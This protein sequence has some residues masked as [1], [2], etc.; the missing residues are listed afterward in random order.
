MRSIFFLLCSW[1]LFS[2][3]TEKCPYAIPH[4]RI[5]IGDRLKYSSASISVLC[6]GLY[7]NVSVVIKFMSPEFYY[8]EESITRELNVTRIMSES[9]LPGF[10]TLYLSG[11]L[12]STNP[13]VTYMVISQ[14]GQTLFDTIYDYDMTLNY[15]IDIIIQLIDRLQA[16]WYYG[17]LHRDIK[18][19]N[20]AFG[21]DKDDEHTIYLFD[22]G[23]STTYPAYDRKGTPAFSPAR[24]LHRTLP[25]DELEC[26]G[27]IFIYLLHKDIPWGI[28]EG[29]HEDLAP[30]KKYITIENLCMVELYKNSSGHEACIAYFTFIRNNQ[31]WDDTVITS[32][33]SDGSSTSGSNSDMSPLFTSNLRGSP[34]SS[35]TS[36]DVLLTIDE[37]EIYPDY[38]SLREILMSFYEPEP[39]VKENDTNSSVDAQQS[40]SALRQHQ[41]GG[42]PN[43]NILTTSLMFDD[44][45]L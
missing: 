41:D 14:L 21:K 11:R 28:S 31:V 40:S 42:T 33:T 3:K 23:E 2:A 18:L 29:E 35:S 10:P 30:I 22:F 5:L 45:D 1:F 24:I 39:D 13:M 12:L 17:F 27:Y 36:N 37:R 19:S 32:S 15:K 7:D 26:L 34:T 4:A 9:K 43:T 38:E 8:Y 6:K 25:I 16:L 44:E 20:I